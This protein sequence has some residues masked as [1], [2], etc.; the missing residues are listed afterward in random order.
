MTGA[1]FGIWH[2]LHSWWCGGRHDPSWSRPYLQRLQ[3][4]YRALQRCRAA[5]AEVRGVPGPVGRSLPFRSTLCEGHA[6]PLLPCTRR[7]LPP[8]R[9]GHVVLPPGPIQRHSGVYKVPR[10]RPDV[11]TCAESAN[12]RA[13]WQGDSVHACACASTTWLTNRHLQ[14]VTL[15][16]RLRAWPAVQCGPK[17][18]VKS[19]TG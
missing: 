4:R 11:H 19:F 2:L 12:A 15:L 13:Q 6:F 8:R 17:S 1:R 9:C 18:S 14:F 5:T 16:V 10:H 7:S 3:E